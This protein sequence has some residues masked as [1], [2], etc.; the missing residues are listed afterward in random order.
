M[1]SLERALEATLPLLSGDYYRATMNP[2]ESKK[3][4][5]AHRLVLDILSAKSHPGHGHE[6]I[7]DL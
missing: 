3:P 1:E 7:G 5:G 6:L 2:S 4:R